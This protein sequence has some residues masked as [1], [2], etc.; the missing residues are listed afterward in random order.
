MV[1]NK[2]KVKHFLN[3]MLGMPV[4]TQRRIFAHFAANLEGAARSRPRLAASLLRAI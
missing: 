4:G 2:T 3:R 1:L